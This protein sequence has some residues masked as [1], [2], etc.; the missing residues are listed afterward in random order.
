MRDEG[1]NMNQVLTKLSFESPGKITLKFLDGREMK[2]PLKYFPELQKL[3]VE[4]RK[5]ILL[6]MIVPYFLTS[7][8][9]SIIWKTL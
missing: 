8:I 4:K 1:D 2:V 9:Q 7:W 5:N 6:S 3:P